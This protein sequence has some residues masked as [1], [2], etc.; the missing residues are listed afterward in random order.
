MSDE[1]TIRF[2]VPAVEG[3][4]LEYIRESIQGGHTSSG[5]PFSTD[6]PPG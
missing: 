2:N 3:R 1:T 4:E 5:G 6:R